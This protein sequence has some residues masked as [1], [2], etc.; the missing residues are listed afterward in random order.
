MNPDT[1]YL[2]SMTDGFQLFR[3]ALHIKAGTLDGDAEKYCLEPEN[4]AQFKKLL[5]L[6]RKNL[7]EII[8]VEEIFEIV[9]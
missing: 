7:G 5:P 6:H 3:I 2:I 8:E 9:T 4:K 1:N